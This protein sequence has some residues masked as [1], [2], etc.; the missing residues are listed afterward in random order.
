MAD[1]DQGDRGRILVAAPTHLNDSVLNALRRRG[2]VLDRVPPGSTPKAVLAEARYAVLVLEI[3][4]DAGQIVAACQELAA[5]RPLL[6]VMVLTASPRLDTALAALRAGAYDYLTWPLP[7]DA[8]AIA[9]DRA[10]RHRRLRREVRRLR[11]VLNPGLGFDGIIGESP[12]MRE[13]FDLMRRVADSRSTV[14][15]TGETGTGKELVARALHRGSRR[16]DGPFVAVNC[17]ALPEPLLESELFGHVR[18]AFT[19]ARSSRKGLLLAASGGT[20]FLDELGDMP[21]ALQVKLL[22]ALQDRVVRPIGGD[23]EIPF[24]AR[25]VTATN[26]DLETLVEQGV[27]REDL[28]YRVNVIHIE[29]PPLRARGG[30]ILLLAEHFLAQACSVAERAMTPLSE[31]AARRLFEYPWPGNIRELENAI[32]RAVALAGEEVSVEDLPGRV[33]TWTPSHVL[34][35]SDAPD[36]LVTLRTLEERYVRRVLRMVGGNRSSAARI[37]GIDRKSLYRK[38]QRFGIVLASPQRTHD[39][40]AI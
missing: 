16:R 23:A 32:E 28:Y 17:A 36:E 13:V 1:A 22:R 35:S 38:M 33:R 21:L 6:D 3:E 8:L 11:R 4:G 27:F 18:G 37:L 39:P 40:E 29:L 31:P 14:L 20:L 15:I 5:E 9:L 25:I 7:V 2:F 34:V 12:A 19:D 26:R 10:I 30:D 24:D